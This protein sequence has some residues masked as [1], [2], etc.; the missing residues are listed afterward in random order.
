MTTQEIVA[1]IRRVA[2]TCGKSK[3][4][5][6]A[7]SGLAYNTVNDVITPGRDRA[8]SLETLQAVARAVGLEIRIEV[9]RTDL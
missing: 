8:W 5:I 1:E 6:V 9:T 7:D 4:K 3:I 2:A